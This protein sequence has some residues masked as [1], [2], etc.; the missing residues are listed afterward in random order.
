[1]IDY[2]NLEA[3]FSD[4]DLKQ[5]IKNNDQAGMYIKMNTVKL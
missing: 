3:F 2:I 5:M 4:D 1:M